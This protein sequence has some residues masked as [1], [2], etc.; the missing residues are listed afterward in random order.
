M[1]LW[2]PIALSLALIPITPCLGQNA[3][4]LQRAIQIE[5]G[6]IPPELQEALNR[7][8]GVRI[9]RNPGGQSPNSRNR[10]PTPEQQRSKMLQSIRIN[11][12]TSGILEARI[13][14]RNEAENPPAVPKPQPAPENETPEQKKQREDQFK[15]LVYKREFEQFSRDLVLGNW[16]KVASYLEALPD[17]DAANVFSR[18]VSLLG[19]TVS[20]QPRKELAKAG[21]RPHKQPQYFR[22][23]EFFS[24]TDASKKAPADQILPALANLIKGERKPPADFFKTLAEGTRYFGKQN[25]ENQI[26]TARLLIEASHLDEATPFLPDRETATSEKNHSALNLLSRY[27]AESHKAKRGKEHLQQAWELSLGVIGEKKAAVTERAEALYRALGL[28]P[29]LEG[30][31]GSQ[32]LVNTFANASSEGFEILAAVG[33]LAS[34]VREHRSPDFRLE[35]LKL[36]SAAVTALTSNDQ[37]DLKPWQEILTLYARNWNA[38]AE[39]SYQLDTTSSM[40][41]QAQVDAYGNIFYGSFQRPNYSSN[42]RITPPITSALLLRTRPGEKWLSQVDAPVRVNNLTQ[43]AKLLLKVKEENQAF[44]I[45]KDLSSV[46]P[47]ETKDLVRE[48]IRVWAENNNPNQASQYRSRYSYFYGY[49]QRAETI[50]LT[51]SKQER[52]LKLLAKMVREVRELG[53]DEDFDEEFAD[54]FIQAHSKAEVWRV[55]ALNAVFGETAGLPPTTTASLIRRMRGNLALLWPDPKLQQQAKTNRKDKELEAQVFKGYAA[56]KSLCEE[57]LEN[58]QSDWSLQVQLASLIYEESNYKASLGSHPDHSSIKALALEDLAAAAETYAKTLPLPDESGENIEA[59]TTWFYAALGSPNLPALK[60]EHQPVPGEYPKIKAALEALP[61]DARKRHLDNFARTLNARLANVSADLKYRFLEAALSITG[62]HELI[63]E[64]S[65]IFQYY[66]DLVTEIE[67]DVHLDGADRIDP[68]HPFGL[69]V[70]LRHTKE[71]ERES[72]GFQRYLINQNNSPYSYNY[73]RPTEDYRDKFEKA[74]RNTLA[75]HFEVISL[76]FHN[77]KVTS[78]TDPQDGWTVTPYAYFLL[79]PKGPQIDAIPPLKI[80]LDFLDTSGYVVLPIASAAIPIDASGQGDVAA[81]PYRDLSVTMILDQKEAAKEGKIALEIRAT[82]H[83]LIPP[84][85]QLVKLPP[86]GFTIDSTDD[87]ELQVDELDAR[88]EDGAPI[89][90]HEWRLV[91]TPE[92]DA[93]PASFT[94]PEVLA[95]LS[96]KEDEGLTIQKYDDVDLIEVEATTP[97]IAGKERTSPLIWTIPVV[98]LVALV[99]FLVF[100]PRKK[101]EVAFIGPELPATL[102]PVSLLAFLENLLE[103]RSLSDSTRGQ[104]SKTIL[105]LKDRAFGP[106]PDVPGPEELRQIGLSSL[107]SLQTT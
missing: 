68:E 45:L 74:A 22:P 10:Q 81:R 50:P 60:T 17:G 102:T 94:F 103:T 87:R 76:T 98:L 71:I 58:H 62:P 48:M 28:V 64:A 4:P 13:A 44:P 72:G 67:L 104:L 25:P 29:D 16:D 6:N 41:P 37:I 5:S 91:L 97:L 69:F 84:L 100:R 70:N 24:L 77:S 51:R 88:T 61:E 3:V 23:N 20:V 38:E 106:S 14:E 32:W 21:A 83:G 107:R 89:S 33:T 40:R 78:R 46:R 96:T 99:L 95:T 42:S 15:T 105:S 9:S 80:D 86:K 57:A 8:A 18:I 2:T 39:R 19:S 59:F 26:R 85:E 55:E 27:H 52:N 7:E 56:A 54:A 36:Q 79:K 12:T 75:E 93:L 53:L 35:Q 1:K 11:R 63:E 34:Q 90:T 43:T 30:D 65:Q 73:G 66:Q 31:A 49:N 101:E 47:E 92:G 82:G